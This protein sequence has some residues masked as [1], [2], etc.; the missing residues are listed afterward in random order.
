[1]ASTLTIKKSAPSKKEQGGRLKPRLKKRESTECKLC[2][3]IKKKSVPKPLKGVISI[4]TQRQL[5]RQGLIAVSTSDNLAT[6]MSIKDYL[7]L[8]EKNKYIEEVC[9][10]CGKNHAKK[11]QVEDLGDKKETAPKLADSLRRGP[12]LHILP[13]PNTRDRVRDLVRQR[14][15]RDRVSEVESM[16]NSLKKPIESN[17]K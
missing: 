14:S 7:D 12:Y 3:K 17:K 1:M 10:K 11:G 5:K 4:K 6:T 16:Y 9:V 15:A 13:L 8:I 2:H